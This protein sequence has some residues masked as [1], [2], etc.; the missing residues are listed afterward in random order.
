VY[1][2]M[3]PT[4][5]AVGATTIRT[6]T[7]PTPGDDAPEYDDALPGAQTELA[8]SASETAAHTAWALDDGPEWQPP[9][10]T[11]GRITAVAITAAVLAVV[12]AAG[13]A[14]YHLRPAPE[15]SA[16]PAIATSAPTTTV[17]A[18]PVEVEA[19]DD[20]KG[21]GIPADMV[22]PPTKTVSAP[23]KTVTVQAPVPTYE[24]PPVDMAAFDSQ[25]I[26]NLKAQGWQV[27][28]PAKSAE[29]ARLACSMLTN[30]ATFDYV[31]NYLATQSQARLD[32]GQAFASTAMRTYP[33]CP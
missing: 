20:R 25:F 31:A 12:A 7:E 6:M 28:Q 24:P 9:F 18:P 14:G 19:A 30:G 21:W 8:P 15:P 27:W 26:R 17:A 29:T 32:E 10:W 2:G 33:N 11:S 22:P 23:A 1:T 3:I 5:V 4:Q 13:L 16:A